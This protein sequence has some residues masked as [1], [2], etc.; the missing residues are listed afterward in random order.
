MLGL[1]VGF[2][3]LAGNDYPGGEFAPDQIENL[4]QIFQMQL[5]E[6]RIVH[7]KQLTF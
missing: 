4:Q 5:M 7:R 1:G 6:A 3:K 2:Y